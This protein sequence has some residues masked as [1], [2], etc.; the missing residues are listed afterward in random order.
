MLR[1]NAHDHGIQSLVSIQRI[2]LCDAIAGIHRVLR[3][4]LNCL[5][6][7]IRRHHQHAV[8]EVD[9]AAMA[10]CEPPVVQ[11][12]QQYV[13][14]IV[15]RFFDFVEQDQR[16]RLPT[17]GFGE[18][19]TFFVTD[20]PRRGANQPSHRMF[21]HEL[22]HVDPNHRFGAVKEN[23]SEGLAQF[24]FTH[25]RRPQEHKGTIRLARIRQA[26]T[27]P[28]HRLADRS[29]RLGL[30]YNALAQRLL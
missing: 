30:A 11:H 18:I 22:R 20:I 19:T 23:L 3:Q 17:H 4:R 14:Y 21:F 13:E 29:N 15:V 1:H 7:Q 6:T 2:G 5:G 16:V 24:S 27:G 10:I 25:A 9:S 8:T 12:L 26:C 28:S